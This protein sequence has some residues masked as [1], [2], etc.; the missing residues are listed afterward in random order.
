MEFQ[1]M[2]KK[3]KINKNKPI[4]QVIYIV[5]G[6]VTEPELL[7][8]IFVK[9]LNYS[10]I[11]YN[12]KNDNFTPITFQGSD[13]YS[14]VFI[15]PSKYSA[16]VRLKPSDYL[17]NIYTNL[18]NTYGL[19]PENSATF[20]L[21]DRDRKSNKRTVVEHLLSKLASSRGND[22]ADDYEMNG[23]LLLSYPCV[24]AMLLQANSDPKPLINGTQAKQYITNQNY[25]KTRALQS[26]QSR[27]PLAL[28]STS[29]RRNGTNK[30]FSLCHREASLAHRNLHELRS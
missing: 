15:V 12:K 13:K 8:H 26:P 9:L 19:D 4:G 6:D 27:L 24:E 30:F 29:I 25:R 28:F 20:F 18:R 3:L 2:N 11:S 14:K 5:E 10:V 7:K 23:L 16:L 17:D 1:S 21:F 22:N